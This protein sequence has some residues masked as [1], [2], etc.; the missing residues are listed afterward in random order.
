MDALDCT[1]IRAS[2]GPD[3][4]LGQ[5]FTPW[6]F[7]SFSQEDRDR[8]LETGGRKEDGATAIPRGRYRLTVTHCERLQCDTPQL[9]DVPGF[10]AAR[11]YAAASKL[12]SDGCIRLGMQKR[13]DS[14]HDG[15]RALTRL[16]EFI[17]NAESQNDTV[18]VVVR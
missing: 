1:L 10:K 5:F 17:R 2:F 7:L 15:A 11:I 9:L 13:T 4:C 14:V 8:H 16:I 18:W 6:H 12:E 3:Y